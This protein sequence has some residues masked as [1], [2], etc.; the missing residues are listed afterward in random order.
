MRLARGCEIGNS[1]AVGEFPPPGKC[2]VEYLGTTLLIF[3]CV[4]LG[5]VVGSWFV[6]EVRRTLDVVVLGVAMNV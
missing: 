2:M 5:C 1:A 3:G 6:G 4:V